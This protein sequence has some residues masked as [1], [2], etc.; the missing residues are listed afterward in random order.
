MEK[1]TAQTDT[2]WTNFCRTVATTA[3]IVTGAR[4]ENR[5]R[6]MMEVTDAIMSVWGASRVG[7]HLSPRGDTASMGN[8]DAL[9]TFGY[10]AEELGKRGIAFICT[11]EHLGE[12][13][14]SPKLKTLFGGVLIANEGFNA[15]SAQKELNSKGVDAVAFGR[16]FI[17]NPDLPRRL[18]LQPLNL[19]EAKTAHGYGAAN[20]VTGYTDYPTLPWPSLHGGATP[21]SAPVL[22]DYRPT[23]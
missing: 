8:S 1:F 18:Q 22:P 16:L 12:D 21:W 13:R 7:M 10:A 20:A 5:A 15:A 9:A 3:Q 23:P 17:A 6:L 19:P 4:I 14:I 11:R 2:C